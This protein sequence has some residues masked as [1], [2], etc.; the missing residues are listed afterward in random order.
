MS[1]ISPKSAVWSSRDVELAADGLFEKGITLLAA[2]AWSSLLDVPDDP[3]IDFRSSREGR[4]LAGAG[5]FLVGL[6]EEAEADAS[7]LLTAGL[8]LLAGRAEP[9]G[10]RTVFGVGFGV[11]SALFLRSTFSDICSSA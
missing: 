10:A 3:K 4:F 2:V 9:T 11:L 1:P 6:L 5:R 7:L 8:G